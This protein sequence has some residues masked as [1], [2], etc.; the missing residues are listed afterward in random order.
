M[1]RVEYFQLRKK[2]KMHIVRFVAKTFN[3]NFRRST[4]WGTWADNRYISLRQAFW[5]MIV[6]PDSSIDTVY[7]QFKTSV[8]CSTPTLFIF[9]INWKNSVHVF[10]TLQYK[11]ILNI[12]ILKIKIC[13]GGGG[14]IKPLKNNV[15]THG[16]YKLNIVKMNGRTHLMINGTHIINVMNSEHVRP[17]N[18]ETYTPVHFHCSWFVYIACSNAVF[19]SNTSD[20]HSR[21]Y[22][23][24][25]PR[26][27]CL[28]FRCNCLRRCLFICIKEEK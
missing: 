25:I 15:W 1:I 3:L 28:G 20:I 21:T 24:Y 9:L 26:F 5:K 17:S 11:L 27:G 22:Y 6:D 18:H 13:K 16:I 8:L 14:G 4:H 19:F 12:K 23:E 10:N 7:W 2:K